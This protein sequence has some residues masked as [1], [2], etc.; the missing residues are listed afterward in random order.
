MA[1]KSTS[2]AENMSRKLAEDIALRI[3]GAAA[4]RVNSVRQAKD[5]NGWPMLFISRNGNEAAGQPVIAL[6]IAGQ[7]AVSKDILGNQIIAAAPHI[8]ELAYELS[9]PVRAD[10]IKVCYDAVKLGTKMQLKEIAAATAV[11]EASMNAAA[12]VDEEDGLYWPSKGV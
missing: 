2:K 4:G 5:A 3:K 12:V 6:R 9:F 11:T 1:F 7:D 10:I 8:M